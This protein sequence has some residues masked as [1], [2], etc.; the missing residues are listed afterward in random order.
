MYTIALSAAMPESSNTAKRQKPRRCRRGFVTSDIQ[1]LSSKLVEQGG[2]EPPTS[3]VRGMRSP[4]WATAAY[5]NGIIRSN[6]HKGQSVRRLR[7]RSS[8]MIQSQDQA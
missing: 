8:A 2:F 7:Q 1:F 4:N 5:R 6:S 3:S